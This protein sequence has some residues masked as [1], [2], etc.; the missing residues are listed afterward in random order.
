MTNPNFKKKYFRGYGPE[1]IQYTRD[2]RTIA[3]E[4]ERRKKLR[5]MPSAWEQ[6]IPFDRR[7]HHCTP[8]YAKD[9]RICMGLPINVM[10][11]IINLAPDIMGHYEAGKDV[12]LSERALDRYEE[13]G[14]EYQRTRVRPEIPA[15]AYT[16]PLANLP[17]DAQNGPEFLS[18]R[19]HRDRILRNRKHTRTPDVRHTRTPDVADPEWDDPEGV[20]IDL[21]RQ[22][23][24]EVDAGIYSDELVEKITRQADRRQLTNRRRDDTKKSWE[25]HL[26]WALYGLAS[27]TIGVSIAMIFDL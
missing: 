13:V 10:C 5:S 6:P 25:D 4:I 7:I 17:R 21:T 18:E 12:I 8:G 1:R 27:I 20:E 24:R 3:T 19:R 15:S 26:L 23:Q 9:L 14:R 2:S 11:H 16:N 22:E